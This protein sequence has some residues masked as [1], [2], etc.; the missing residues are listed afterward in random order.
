MLWRDALLKLG[1]DSIEYFFFLPKVNQKTFCV[2]KKINSI[3]LTFQI[4]EKNNLLKE[5]KFN[6]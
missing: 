2:V 5:I 1:F 4:I 6:W 3:L